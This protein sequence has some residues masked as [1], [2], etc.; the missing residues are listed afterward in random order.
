MTDSNTEIAIAIPA[1]MEATMFAA[2]KHRGQ[3]RKNARGTPYINHPI[4]VVSLMA[5]VGGIADIEVLQAGMLHD[6]VEDTNTS[7]E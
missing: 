7:P 2:D 4:D 5:G 6:T 1:L 3:R